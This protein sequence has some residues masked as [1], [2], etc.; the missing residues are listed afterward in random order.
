MLKRCELSCRFFFF[1]FFNGPI[2]A[3]SCF[4]THW[5]VGQVSVLNK[6]INKKIGALWSLA[7]R[8]QDTWIANRRTVRPG[9]GQEG[10]SAWAT[11]A[12]WFS[13]LVPQNG[14]GDLQDEFPRKKCSHHCKQLRTVSKIVNKCGSQKPTSQQFVPSLGTEAGLLKNMSLQISLC[15]WIWVR[16]LIPSHL[17][18][19]FGCTFLWANDDFGS[20]QELFAASETDRGLCVQHGKTGLLPVT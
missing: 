4:W 7:P 18:P 8:G 20:S 17:S 13:V 12:N 14:C 16:K 11:N 6:E 2:P 15:W 19:C 5:E 10:V 1:F 9:V 3:V